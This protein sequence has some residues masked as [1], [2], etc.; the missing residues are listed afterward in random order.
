MLSSAWPH[1][2]IT[3]HCSYSDTFCIKGIIPHYV[4]LLI[5]TIISRLF[6]III[7]AHICRKIMNHILKVLQPDWHWKHKNG[8]RWRL[9]QVIPVHW[10]YIL[11]SY[12]LPFMSLC[13]T[14]YIWLILLCKYVVSTMIMD[15]RAFRD[16]FKSISEIAVR[17]WR[18]IWMKFLW[19]NFWFE[20]KNTFSDG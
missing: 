13:M 18:S 15:S 17:G 16:A 1:R 19:V 5:I 8:Q 7:L 12:C 3:S 14:I 4:F 10:G 6:T 11:T 2:S 20:L 9:V